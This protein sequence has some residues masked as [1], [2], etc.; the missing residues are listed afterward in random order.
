M[1]AFSLLQTRL[2]S[3]QVY[4]ISTPFLAGKSQREHEGLSFISSDALKMSK[5]GNQMAVESR[6]VGLGCSSLQRTE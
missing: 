5:N 6:V 3:S 4:G 2:F 1:W